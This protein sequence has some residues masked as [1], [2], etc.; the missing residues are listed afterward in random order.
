MR[1]ISEADGSLFHA[2]PPISLAEK[3]MGWIKSEL[4]PPD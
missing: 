4:Q 3:A 2:V 1:V